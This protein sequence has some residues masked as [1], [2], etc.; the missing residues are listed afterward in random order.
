MDVSVGPQILEH[1]S[2]SVQITS[3]D[4]KWIPSSARFVVMG[5]YAR[6]TGCLQVYELDGTTLKLQKEVETKTSI[7]CG[8]FGASGLAERHLATGNFEGYLQMWDLER[9]DKP[10]MDVKAHTSIVLSSGPA[11][12]GDGTR[13]GAVRQG[14]RRAC[15]GRATER[16]AGCIV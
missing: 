11:R 9:S 4:V 13:A 8:T 6:A 16:C 12:T 14:R 3:Y 2:Q 10:V 5:S 7:K 1:I 15:V